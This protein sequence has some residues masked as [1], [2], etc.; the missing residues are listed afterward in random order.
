MNQGTTANQTFAEIWFPIQMFDCCFENVTLHIAV[1]KAAA[2][3]LK[4]AATQRTHLPV[5][6][7]LL[8][9]F[10]FCFCFFWLKNCTPAQNEAAP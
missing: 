1:N 2:V 3:H 9:F 4:A 6:E 7:Q 10:L 5:S 8:V